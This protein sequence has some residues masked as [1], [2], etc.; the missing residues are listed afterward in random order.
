MSPQNPNQP[1]VRLR[2]F[3]REV[4]RDR[5]TGVV[6]LHWSRQIGK[7]FV[8]AHWAVDRLLTRPGRLVTVL[9]NS[10][11]NGAEFVRKCAEACQMLGVA[12]DE[13]DESP[14]I[15]YENMRMEVRITVG[16][17]VGRIKVLAANPRTARGFSGDLILDE[18][19][20][21]ENSWAIWEAAEP[22]LSSN[23]DYLCRIAST[24]N[25]KHNAFYTFC[26]G[27][28]FKLSR[29]TRTDAHA[30]GVNI[31]DP[32]TREPIAPEEAR[33]RSLDKA[34]YDQNYECAFRNENS[35]LLTSE[36]VSAAED[37]DV[38][39]MCEMDWTAVTLRRLRGC[40]FPLYGGYDVARRR[41]Y[42]V[43]SIFEHIGTMMLCR[44]ILRM[45]GMRLPEQQLRL[46]AVM[47]SVPKL[48]RVCIDMTGLG[49]GLF[50]YSQQRH[51]GRVDGVD[52]GR[53]VPVPDVIKAEGRQAKTV[54]V[55]EAMAT[56]L[57]RMYEQHRIR[58]PYDALLRED[59][60]KPEKIV[61]PGGRVSIAAVRDEAG[62]A[63]HFWSFALALEAM[64]AG[65]PLEYEP[66]T[67]TAR[68]ETSR[69]FSSRRL[70]GLSGM[71]GFRT[72]RGRG[73][74]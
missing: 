70:D 69:H 35:A 37:P 45:E 31:Y 65:G 27:G 54:R 21:H 20:F 2:P 60:L 12:F 13:M 14:D 1:L 41:D 28:L 8:L 24:G 62:H 55:T 32:R 42:S 19:A 73:W 48:R 52:F 29:V 23:P 39:E 6:V 50:E 7:S 56:E 33:R 53:S 57:L 11:D 17:R 9:S 36:L 66:I 67:G 44:A 47:M 5:E 15:E 58:H 59:L 49:L 51:G 4:F 40:H 38:G 10:R 72:G 34:A 25:G 18:F 26:T 64:G 22:I 30:Q 61:T 63:D 43:L 71:G 3:Q 16:G 46:D 74:G 68:E